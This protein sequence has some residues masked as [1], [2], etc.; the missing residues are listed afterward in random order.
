MNITLFLMGMLFLA[1]FIVP[2]IYIHRAQKNKGKNFLKHFAD[3]AL[4]ENIKITHS[5][6]WNENNCIGIDEVSGK[7][8]ILSK[9]DEK[10]ETT[11][12]DL[13]SVTQCKFSP[14]YRKIKGNKNISVT[15]RIDIVFSFNDSKP[16]KVVN[17]YNTN[18]SATLSE[19]PVF[20]E[21]WC[22]KINGY[23][24]SK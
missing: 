1:F 19:E 9:S 2:V 21:K 14:T 22:N 10:E 18:G 15:E 13:K 8:F 17:F 12:I 4:K 11:Q 3:I 5:E 20:A 6:M 24:Q 16:E 7:L 23:I